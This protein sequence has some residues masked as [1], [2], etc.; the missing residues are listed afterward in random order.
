[1]FCFFTEKP[2][3]PNSYTTAITMVLK[4][5][6]L[7]LIYLLHLGRG[8]APGVL[9]ME[10]VGG[11][12]KR[13]LGNWATDVF[14]SHY[15]TKLPLS[16]MRAMSGHD[17][18]RG[19]FYHPRSQFK[20]D[21]TH[22]H[23]PSLLFPWV[24]EALKDTM[25][26]SNHTAYGFLSLLKNL[27]WVILQDAAVMMAKS[28]RSHYLYDEMFKDVFQSKTFQDY[29]KKMAD[30]LGVQEKMD[31]NKLGTLTETVLPYVN[32]NLLKVNTTLNTI[33][34]TVA[35]LSQD[36][37]A[38]D[39][40]VA[41]NI[42]E[43]SRVI[44]QLWDKEKDL[45][46]QEY[47]KLATIKNIIEITDSLRQ[48]ATNL[49]ESD[50]VQVDDVI[51]GNDILVTNNTNTMNSIVAIPTTEMV[52]FKPAPYTIPLKFDSFQCIKTHYEK[53][54]IPR[55]NSK[56]IAWRKHLS[57]SEK[58]RLQRVNR[59]MIAFH[60]IITEDKSK[61]IDE[62][63]SCFQDYYKVHNRNLAKLADPFARDILN[64]RKSD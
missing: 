19:Y 2:M 7:S 15:D 56:S 21:E 48:K 55:N 29:S 58:R 39:S 61:C 46:A 53:E 14:G 36:V 9:E 3:G 10:E 64:K 57:S 5:L 63:V 34:D 1:M 49:L 42:T 17:A 20:G 35:R 44:K 32:G 16:A 50:I 38:M 60:K 25:N 59:V 22:T 12:D 33:D 11:L 62:I 37:I 26:T 27:R 45:I 18:R 40:N 28:N 31:P 23:L 47:Q 6:G 4:L 54:I 41:D 13:A 43:Q 30:H 52:P 8:I 24:D 51:L